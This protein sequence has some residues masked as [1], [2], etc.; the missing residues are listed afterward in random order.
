MPKNPALFFSFLLLFLTFTKTN[1]RKKKNY[2]NYIFWNGGMFSASLNV[3]IL[4][5][6]SKNKKNYNS[7]SQFWSYKMWLKIIVLFVFGNWIHLW[8][9]T[10]NDVGS[11]SPVMNLA[12]TYPRE[13]P[14]RG[15]CFDH[16]VLEK[17][18]AKMQNP[19]STTTFHHNQFQSSNL[20]FISFQS[21]KFQVCLIKASLTNFV[22]YWS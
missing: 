8:N 17:K 11:L 2:F 5:I 9:V 4:H 7:K 14:S 12:S 1:L 3:H 6:L 16:F 20:V 10:R 21:S 15:G 19:L 22:I 18:N 13:K